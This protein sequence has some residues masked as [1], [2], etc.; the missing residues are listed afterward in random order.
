MVQRQAGSLAFAA[1]VAG[2][3][4][5]LL[6]C[7]SDSQ[8]FWHLLPGGNP[9]L[10]AGFFSEPLVAGFLL[11]TPFLQR[12][13]SFHSGWSGRSWLVLVLAPASVLCADTL[14]KLSGHLERPGR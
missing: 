9:L 5:A 12:I 14:H 3:M 7:R 13:F 11:L 4:A 1:I 6:A 2:Q 8:P 10:W